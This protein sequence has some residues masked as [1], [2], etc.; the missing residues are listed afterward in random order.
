MFSS[1]IPAAMYPVIYIVFIA[2]LT[3]AYAIVLFPM[4]SRSLYEKPKGLYVAVIIALFLAFF[5][6]L[7]PL[8]GRYFGDMQS[9]NTLYL[10]FAQGLLKPHTDTDVLWGNLMYAFAQ[11]AEAKYFFLFVELVYIIPLLIACIRL[12]KENAAP[13]FVF[14]IS[15]MSFFAYATNGIRNGAA[16]SLFVLALTFLKGDYRNKIVYAL[17]CI[18]SYGFHNSMALPILA[19]LGA[20]F[21]KNP[22]I[23][24]YVWGAALAVTVLAGSMVSDMLSNLGFDQRFGEYLSGSNYENTITK[25]GFRWDFLLYSFM[26]ILLGWYV[27]F[28]RKVY[29]RSYAILLGTYIYANAFWLMVIRSPYSNRFAYLSW[30]LYPIVLSYPMF[31]LPAWQKSPGLKTAGVL[32]GHF[33]FTFYIWIK[34]WGGM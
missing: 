20:F 25:E 8:S 32:A 22:K 23:M 4:D 3:L 29:T 33:L 26:P 31:E 13:I 34:M 14:V 10:N 11:V 17:L 9:Y 6:G 28:R 30:C 18:A 5:L 2:I 1:V 19:S 27:I 16:S 12:S 7:R 21:I 15:A 24:F